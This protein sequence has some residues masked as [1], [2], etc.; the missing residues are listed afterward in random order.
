VSNLSRGIRK[1]AQVSFILSQSMRLTD[2]HMARET[3]RQKGLALY[4]MQLHSKN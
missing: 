1:W 3:D 2:R 4:Y